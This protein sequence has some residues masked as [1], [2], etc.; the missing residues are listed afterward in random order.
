MSAIMCTRE[1][2]SNMSASVELCAIDFC[3]EL[4]DALYMSPLHC[5]RCVV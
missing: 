2:Y 4:A 5:M 3:T 1:L